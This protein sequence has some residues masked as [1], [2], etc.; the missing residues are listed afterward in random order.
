MPSQIAPWDAGPTALRRSAARAA[1]QL[2]TERAYA[3]ARGAVDSAQSALDVAQRALAAAEAEQSTGLALADAHEAA[4]AVASA[5]ADASQRLLSGLIRQM[6]QQRTGGASIDTLANRAGQSLLSA[7][8]GLDRMQ[9]LTGNVSGIRD[10]AVADAA[11]ARSLLDQEA[12]ARQKAALV[13]IDERRSDVD[14]AQASL[15]DATA[16]LAASESLALG[17]PASVAGSDDA[18]AWLTRLDTGQLSTQGW[19]LPAAGRITD[20]FGPRPVRPAPGA[21]AFHYATDIG[22]ACDSAVRAATSGV[23]AAVGTVGGYG[24]WILIDHGSGVQ[25]GYAHLATG[26]LLVAVGDS[27]GAG[28]VIAGVGRTGVATGCHLHFEVRVGGT[29]VDPQRFMAARGVALGSIG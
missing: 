1:Q 18:V 11:A 23:V 16:A 5:K 8:G 10:R 7:L 19:A 13:P 21:G 14:S 12:A 6:A 3:A 29:R 22:A 9:S 27:V 20:V 2:E 25:T 15:D 4:A 26:E 17:A 28:Q 24:N